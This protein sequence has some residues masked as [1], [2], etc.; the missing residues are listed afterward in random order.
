MSDTSSDEITPSIAKEML[1]FGQEHCLT[2]PA[3]L[4]RGRIAAALLLNNSDNAESRKAGA[5]L[6]ETNIKEISTPGPERFYSFLGLAEYHA[7][8]KAGGELSENVKVNWEKVVEYANKALKERDAE[9]GALGSELNNERSAAAYL[10]KANALNELNDDT[11]AL[12]T[13]EKALEPGELE[14]SN[15]LLQFLT[16]VIRIY[17]KN[18]QHANIVKEMQQQSPRIRSEWLFHPPYILNDKRDAFREAAVLTR[19]VD[20]VIQVYEDAIEYWQAK[21]TFRSL[22]LQLELGN[23]YRRDARA[24]KMAERTLNNIMDTV[25]EDP[26]QLSGTLPFVMTEM[27][28]ILHENFTTARRK[29]AREK[30]INQLCE[31]LKDL[32]QTEIIESI[33]MGRACLTLAQ[34]WKEY[35]DMRAAKREAEYAFNSCIADLEDTVGWND[36]SALRLLGKVLMFVDLEDDA[37]IALSLQF[38]NL[39]P[40]Y[41]DSSAQQ[42]NETAQDETGVS[43]VPEKVTGEHVSEPESDQR[44]ED[45]KTNGELPQNQ[46]S[47][48]PVSANGVDVPSSSDSPKVSLDQPSTNGKTESGETSSDSSKGSPETAATTVSSQ[49]DVSTSTTTTE[50]PAT[51]DLSDEDLLGDGDAFLC[52][53]PCNIYS[54][55]KWEHG[56]V[57]YNCVDCNDVDFCS[58]CYQTQLKFY[59]DM[60]EGFWFKCCWGKHRFIQQPIDDWKGVK[61]GMIRIGGKQKHWHDWLE[62]VKGRWKR[63]LSQMN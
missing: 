41:D 59:T 23:I 46:T 28:D 7:N 61:N 54:V 27:V 57:F 62:S 49:Q 4:A 47:E 58:D 5:E 34:M 38:S 24:T 53:G 1:R 25:K 6:Y 63:R 8:V 50:P 9:K 13:C 31:L 21:D 14:Y 3:K 16:I 33:V 17:A 51:D 18:K 30:I 39:N 20:F 52:N 26:T 45:L 29:L 60:G 37:M 48:Q 42:N 2:T 55:D 12:E 40:T 35:G 43:G 44:V 11:D 10:L 19:R 22:M 56:T 36:H 32:K 15:K